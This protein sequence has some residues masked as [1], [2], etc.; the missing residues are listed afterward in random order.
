MEMGAAGHLVQDSP[1]VSGSAAGSAK[2]CGKGV[3][4]PFIS[5]C[6]CLSLDPQ[7]LWGAQDCPAAQEDGRNRIPPGLWLRGFRHQ[8][9]CQGEPCS[10]LPSWHCPRWGGEPGGSVPLRLSPGLGQAGGIPQK[11]SCIPQESCTQAEIPTWAAAKPTTKPLMGI[12][13]VQLIK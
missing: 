6:P 3:T 1:D 13:S 9:G 7:H 4:L 2:V 12:I 11:M 8:A 5:H 10:S